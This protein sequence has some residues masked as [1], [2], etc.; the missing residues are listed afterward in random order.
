MT[1]W[2]SFSKS[3]GYF[4]FKGENKKKPNKKSF[5]QRLLQDLRLLSD[6]DTFL[7]V[8][9]QWEPL[10]GAMENAGVVSTAEFLVEKPNY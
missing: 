10:D 5:L 1:L 9:A 2:A 4:V 6:F 7:G 3:C 8:L